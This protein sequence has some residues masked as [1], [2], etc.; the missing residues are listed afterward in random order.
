MMSSQNS[1]KRRSRSGIAVIEFM[2]G[3]GVLLATFFG[4]FEIGYALIQYDRLQTAVAQGARYASLVA[5]DS[6][7][8]TPSSG[9]QSAVKNM[10]L[11]GSPGTGT[12]PVVTG[13]TSSNVTLTVTFANGIPSSMQVTITGYTINALFGAYTLTGKPRAVFPY[14]G[15]WAPA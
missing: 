3:S 5:Y 14:Q 4:T 13:L 2:L 9:F 10:V 8:S 6:A 7:N 15:L 12:T 1:G 11:Y